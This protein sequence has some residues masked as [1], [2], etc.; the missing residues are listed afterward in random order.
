MKLLIKL[1]LVLVFII[2]GLFHRRHVKPEHEARPQ[3][4]AS[5]TAA[6]DKEILQNAERL[7][8][9][10]RQCQQTAQNNRETK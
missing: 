10:I 6:V 3:A 9:T 4:K 1:F 5:Q 2:V 7:A 8:K